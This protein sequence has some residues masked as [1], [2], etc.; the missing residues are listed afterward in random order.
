[1]SKEARQQDV[2][3]ALKFGNHKGASAKLDLLRKLIGKDVKFGYSF[4]LPLSSITLIPGIC[5][6][7]MNIMVQIP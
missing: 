4:A 2:L 5:M 6:A 1:M 3:D 7:P